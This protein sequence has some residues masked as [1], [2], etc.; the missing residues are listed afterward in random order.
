MCCFYC[1]CFVVSSGVTVAARGS[2]L[3]K[4]DQKICRPRLRTFPSHFECHCCSSR[5]VDNGVERRLASYGQQQSRIQTTPGRSTE[6]WQSRCI[7]TTSKVIGTSGFWPPSLI[8]GTYQ[9]PT[10]LE[11]PCTIRKLHPE[12]I[13][14]DVGIMS[15]CA[16][17]LDICLEYFIPSP[18]CR[19]T[20]QKNCCREKG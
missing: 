12:N 3:L 8:S 9:R 15:L 2:H 5:V 19:Q 10:K 1:Q 18:R 14:V 20:S 4:F 13:G 7:C 6:A 17:E 16:L 11:V